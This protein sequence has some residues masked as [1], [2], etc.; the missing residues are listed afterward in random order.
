MFRWDRDYWWRWY[1][2]HPF[3]DVSWSLYLWGFIFIDTMQF[4]LYH[5]KAKCWWRVFCIALTTSEFKGSSATASTLLW[6][7]PGMWNIKIFYVCLYV[8]LFVSFQMDWKSTVLIILSMIGPFSKLACSIAR[9]FLSSIW[10]LYIILIILW[11]LKLFLAIK[12]GSFTWCTN[13][14]RWRCFEIHCGCQSWVSRIWVSQMS[15]GICLR[16]VFH[17]WIPLIKVFSTVL[18]CSG[19]LLSACSW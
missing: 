13:H 8:K 6:L 3:L 2:D 14:K 7:Y 19:V 1:Y 5:W 18:Y 12:I 16:V 15:F 17:I 4:G 11:L 10:Y 9:Y